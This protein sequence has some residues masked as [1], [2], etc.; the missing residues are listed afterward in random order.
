MNCFANSSLWDKNEQIPSDLFDPLDNSTTS[1]TTASTTSTTESIISY[2]TV[3]ESVDDKEEENE[4]QV[5]TE[6]INYET[7]GPEVVLLTNV[8]ESSTVTEPIMNQKLEELPDQGGQ[9]DTND[10]SA[11]FVVA[12]LVLII[13]IVI[14][15]II[16]V[17]ELI[18]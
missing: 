5:K 3:E 15:L 11:L 17:R 8:T 6:T 9:E 1:T 2:T 13:V 7:I 12:I 18:Y 10:W 14:A 16:I 4:I